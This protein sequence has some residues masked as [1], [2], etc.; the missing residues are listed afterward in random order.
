MR[1]AL[2]S[3]C[4]QPCNGS[5]L[6]S[7]LLLYC[8]DERV[9]ANVVLRGYSTNHPSRTRAAYKLCAHR[10]GIVDPGGCRARE[11]HGTLRALGGST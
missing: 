7:K 9:A 10:H 2:L 5:G 6:I 11:Y 4:T 3:I 8:L 1:T